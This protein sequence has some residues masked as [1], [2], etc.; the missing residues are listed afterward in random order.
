M[1]ASFPA[2]AGCA[3]GSTPVY[4]CWTDHNGHMNLAAY[5]VAFDRCF[6]RWCN[7]IGIGPRQLAATGRTIFVAEA[8]LVYR[9]ELRLGDQVD[10]GIRVLALSPK[11]MHSHLTMVRRDNGELVCVNEK[12]DVCVD[13]ATRRSAPFPDAVHAQLLALHAH[14]AAWPPPLH[15]GRRVALPGA[16]NTGPRR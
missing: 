13:L 8:H 12:L 11:R 4:R 10:I 15:A 3:I 9:Q 6:A 7:R 2:V 1:P 5:L 14:E 16:D